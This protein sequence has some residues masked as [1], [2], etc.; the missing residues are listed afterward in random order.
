[1]PPISHIILF[2]VYGALAV[3]TGVVAPDVFD[4][5]AI[6][7]GLIVFLIFALAHEIWTRRVNEARLIRSIRIMK[8]AYDK[9]Q[10]EQPV[11]QPPGPQP[12]PDGSKPTA[13]AAQKI[14]TPPVQIS[15]STNPPETSEQASL[16]PLP[17]PEITEIALLQRLLDTLQTA[18]DPGMRPEPGIEDDGG[19]AGGGNTSRPD[20]RVVG[21]SEDSSG[22][23]S[24]ILDLVQSALREDRVDLYLQPIVSLPQRK[25]RFFECYSRVRTETGKVIEPNTYLEPAKSSGLLTAI[26]NILLFRCLQLLGKVQRQDTTTVFFCNLSANTLADDEFVRDIVAYMGR[27][28]ELSAKLVLEMSQKDLDDAPDSLPEYLAALHDAGYR[29]SMDGVRDLDLD[30][31][32]MVETGFRSVKVD[33]TLLLELIAAGR[34]S[35]VRTLKQSLDQHGIDM[36]VERIESEK[37]LLELLDFNVDYGQGFLFGEPRPSKDPN[38][39]DRADG[40]G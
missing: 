27:H 15:T 33:S 29:F 9:L 2:F 21:G 40:T 12:P 22:G 5:P 24:E 35:V 28:R 4:A 8:S 20:L 13:Q 36:I 38:V 10:T 34:G 25:R 18:E 17:S 19:P 16:P 1:M 3:G 23:Q 26:D 32:G 30:L 11:P 31:A 6:L 14:S 37:D 7:V 39:Q